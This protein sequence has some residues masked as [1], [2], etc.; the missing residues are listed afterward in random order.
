[1]DENFKFAFGGNSFDIKTP[2]KD[3]FD[4]YDFLKFVQKQKNLI[5]EV[6]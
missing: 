6:I 4:L 5:T 3:E 2:S 1:M